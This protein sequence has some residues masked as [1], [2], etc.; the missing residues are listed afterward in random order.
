MKKLIFQSDDYGISD[1]VTDGILKGIERGIICQTGLFV[2]MPSSERAARLI[3][4]KRNVAVGIDINLVAGFSVSDPKNVSSLVNSCGHMV[5]SVERM[6]ENKII[7]RDGMLIQFEKDPYDFE[8]TLLETENQVKRFIELMG[9]KPAY[10]HG[11][12]LMTENTNKAAQIVAKKYNVP[13]SFELLKLSGV[14]IVPCT[15]T[16]KPFPIEDQKNTDVT[17]NFINA[18][19]NMDACDVG[20]FICHCGYV[21][22]DLLKETTY[23]LI[24]CKDLECAT[25]NEVR[26]Y[27]VKNN[28]ELTSISKLMSKG[29]SNEY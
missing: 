28:I 22:A 27:L 15:W 20:Y 23:T 5:S 10:L 9:R 21:D 17:Q 29:N 8:Q 19:K 1:A 12:S 16:P 18:L 2:N 11:H 7:G 25:S 6:R 26:D 3:K 14:K 4:D 13:L 24:R